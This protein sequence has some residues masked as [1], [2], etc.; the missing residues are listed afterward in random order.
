MPHVIEQCLQR[1]YSLYH[2]D[3]TEVIQGIP[4]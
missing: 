3:N 2:G 1:T 4:D